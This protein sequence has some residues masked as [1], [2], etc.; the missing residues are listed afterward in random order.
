[1][2]TRK[3][4]LAAY[5]LCGYSHSGLVHIAFPA[6]IPAFWVAQAALAA[7]NVFKHSVFFQKRFAWHTHQACCGIQRVT[8][9]A[10]TF[11][12]VHSRG[13]LSEPRAYGL[14]SRCAMV[15]AAY[16]VVSGVP[17]ASQLSRPCGILPAWLT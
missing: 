6:D 5:K 17:P 11:A 16:G 1:M 8:Y 12:D 10:A 15:L 3:A 7:I 13:V 9:D 14:L 2:V 4:T